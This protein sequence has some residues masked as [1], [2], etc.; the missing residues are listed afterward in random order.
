MGITAVVHCRY[1]VISRKVS[2]SSLDEV[3][4]FFLNL[5]NPSSRTLALGMTASNRNQYQEMFLESRARQ[6]LKA[7][8]LTA[9]CVRIV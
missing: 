2:R 8:N 9:I 3:I 1:Y 5:H 6:A 4:E 7:D